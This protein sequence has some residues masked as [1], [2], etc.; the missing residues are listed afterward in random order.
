MRFTSSGGGLKRILCT[1][2]RDSLGPRFSVRC[3]MTS[4]RGYGGRLLR[5]T[6]RSSVR[7]TRMLAATTGIGLNRVR[8]VSCS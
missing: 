1:L 2:T 3:A 4:M 5:G 7:G 6:V 8:T